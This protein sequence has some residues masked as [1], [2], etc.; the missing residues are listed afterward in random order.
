MEGYDKGYKE[1]KRNRKNK[2]DWEIERNGEN[3]KNVR[4]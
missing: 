2:A 1:N 4:I 3:E